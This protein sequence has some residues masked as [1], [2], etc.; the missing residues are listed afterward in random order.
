MI[1]IN[2][3]LRTLLSA[4]PRGGFD[5]YAVTLLPDEAG[6]LGYSCF[7]GWVGFTD[8]NPRREVRQASLVHADR[9][10]KGW[11]MLGQTA[12][13]VNAPND[14]S[15]FFGFGGNA[16]VEESVARQII[17]GWLEP[18]VAANVGEYGFVSLSALPKSALHKALTPKH[19]M[20]VIKRDSY[21]C[22]ICGRNPNDHG[23][24][25]IHVHHIRPWAAGGVTE[26]TNLITLCHTCHNG[27][28]PHFDSALFRNLPI[29]Q[30]SER[31]AKYL[32]L[33]QLYQARA[34][35]RWCESDV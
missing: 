23:D 16:V 24:L 15:L 6:A 14:M 19:R 9:M 32:E 10:V 1:P 34:F 8:G 20:R 3:R 12:L 25:E 18:S 4:E 7:S 21:R 27:L 35:E 17:P 26:D 2:E 22:R 31:T 29:D 33:L 30:T 11:R 13:I 5:Y 28:D